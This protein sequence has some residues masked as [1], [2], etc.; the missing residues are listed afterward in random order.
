MYT[1]NREHKFTYSPSSVI[2]QATMAHPKRIS[3][4]ASTRFR[5]EHARE[6][7]IALSVCACTSGARL[8]P[9][10]RRP[11]RTRLEA[12]IV[13]SYQLLEMKYTHLLQRR[14]RTLLPGR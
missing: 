9:R 2:H 14:A 5:T 4:Q 13:R 8:V 7:A 6:R 11:R 1:E 10:I 12:P 3:Q